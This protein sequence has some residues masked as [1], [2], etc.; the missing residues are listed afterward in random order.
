MAA[1]NRALQPIGEAVP[2]GITPGHDLFNYVEDRLGTR[3][4]DLHS[5]MSATVDHQF[6][7][8]AH[9]IMQD[10]MVLPPAQQAQLQAIIDNQLL[11]K[12]TANAGTIDGRTIQ[13]IGSELK[14]FVRARRGDPS[15]DTRSLAYLVDDLRDFFENML[16]RQNPAEAGALRDANRGWAH[17]VRLEKATAASPSQAFQGRFTPTTLSAKETQ[18]AGSRTAARGAGLYQDLAEAG[19]E[20]IPSKVA[21]SGTPERLMTHGL[22]GGLYTG[23]ISPLSLIPGA[24][25][26]LLYSRPV[27]AAMRTALTRRPAGADFVADLMRQYGPTTSTRAALALASQTGQGQ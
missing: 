15:A 27:Q 7:A 1:G 23:A 2:R 11:H 18:A 17:L 8:D 9:Q 13:S 19:R 24:A 16:M 6:G 10:A 4:N 26:P 5:R 22:L 20:V 25:I 14:A 21:D 12:F 3:F